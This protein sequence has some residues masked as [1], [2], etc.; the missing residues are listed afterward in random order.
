LPEY[1]CLSFSRPSGSAAILAD[2]VELKRLA[3]AGSPMTNLTGR[4]IRGIVGFGR[5]GVS[6]LVRTAGDQAFGPD[7][8]VSGDRVALVPYDQAPPSLGQTPKPMHSLNYAKVDRVDVE[9]QPDGVSLRIEGWFSMSHLESGSRNP[10]FTPALRGYLYVS[11]PQAGAGWE[12]WMSIGDARPIVRFYL[13]RGDHVIRLRS[14]DES[15]GAPDQLVDWRALSP[16]PV[17]TSS[18]YFPIRSLREQR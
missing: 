8:Y 16:T 18:D 5:P 17:M 12:A 11:G 3:D 14:P 6:P 1:G 13:F 9:Q 15:P 7:P 2:W 10:S 4:P